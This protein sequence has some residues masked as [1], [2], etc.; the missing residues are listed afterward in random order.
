M[1]YLK[2]SPEAGMILNLTPAVHDIDEDQTEAKIPWFY[3][4][5]EKEGR[6]QLGQLKLK[7]TSDPA[8]ATRIPDQSKA[9]YLNPG[10]QTEKSQDQSLRI[11]N[12]EVPDQTR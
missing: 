12:G 7:N 2:I 9:P 3:R 1:S 6:F 8:S 10:N 4:N 5:E 11:Q